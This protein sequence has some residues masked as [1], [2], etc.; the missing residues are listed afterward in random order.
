MIF[1]GKVFS[2]DKSF[3][4]GY[5][6]LV[7]IFTV[8]ESFCWGLLSGKLRDDAMCYSFLSFTAL[9]IFSLFFSLKIL[10]IRHLGVVL[11]E[12]NMTRNLWPSYI[13]MSVSYSKRRHFLLGLLLLWIGLAYLWPSH[14]FLNSNNS[15]I[16]S[17]K[18]IPNSHK[19]MDGELFSDFNDI[20]WFR[21]RTVSLPS[22][23]YDFLIPLSPFF[24][25]LC[26]FK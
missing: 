14:N 18:I 11:V 24:F 16:C 10:F 3:P 7:P 23:S 26:I 2:V 9:R 20:T 12:L 5:D 19:S 4:S 17:F 13:W 22:L 15:N 25:Q 1:L 21:L 6:N 8:L